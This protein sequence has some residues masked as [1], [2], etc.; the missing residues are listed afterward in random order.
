MTLYLSHKCSI[1]ESWTEA[2]Y[3]ER[4]TLKS[5]CILLNAEHHNCNILFLRKPQ[6]TSKLNPYR[7]HTHKVQRFSFSLHN[8]PQILLMLTPCK[9]ILH[10]DVH[11]TTAQVPSSAFLLLRK[12][13]AWKENSCVLQAPLPHTLAFLWVGYTLNYSVMSLKQSGSAESKTVTICLWTWTS[14]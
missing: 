6:T 10:P 2:A 11:L 4:A 3:A 8:P 7:L 9:V 13:L 1:T 12:G 5:V 14:S